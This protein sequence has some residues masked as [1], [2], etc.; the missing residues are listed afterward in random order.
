MTTAVIEWS[1]GVGRA[2][3]VPALA[4]LGRDGLVMAR[5]FASPEGRSSGPVGVL[6]PRRLSVRWAF[7]LVA[8]YPEV[9]PIAV[10]PREVSAA[11]TAVALAF[12]G[13]LAAAAPA[14]SLAPVVCAGRPPVRRTRPLVCHDVRA[15]VNG[16]RVEVAVWELRPFARAAAIALTNGQAA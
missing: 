15:N 12:G 7:E 13:L 3:E 6:V 2:V 4:P 14:G 8:T 1:G 9:G 16:R 11:S 10:W 5:P